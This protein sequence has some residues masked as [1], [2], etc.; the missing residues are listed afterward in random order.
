M[1]V[2]SRKAGQELILGD[3]VRITITKISGNRVTLGVTAPDDVRVIRGELEAIV[4]SFEE[5]SPDLEMAAESGDDDSSNV[6]AGFVVDDEARPPFL[7]A[8]A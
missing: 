2:L 1:L 6:R 4:K 3:N 7:D 5:P 8:F